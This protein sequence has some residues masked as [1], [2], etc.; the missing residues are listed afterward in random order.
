MA[1]E[2][3]MGIVI[4]WIIARDGRKIP[5]YAPSSETKTIVE[6]GKVEV[7]FPS[8]LLT[9]AKGYSHI[10]AK[11]RVI[12]TQPQYILPDNVTC[13]QIVVR[14]SS[15][16]SGTVYLGDSSV[17]IGD[18]YPLDPNDAIAIPVSKE[19]QP[20]VTGAIGDVVYWLVVG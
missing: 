20:Y 10:V 16:N 17:S 11:K 2:L 5:I 15:S 18:G 8:L 6:G 9:Q 13:N 4:G 12:Q 7:T 3:G 19:S 14:A 1:L